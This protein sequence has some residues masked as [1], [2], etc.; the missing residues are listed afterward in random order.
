M[1]LFI[2]IGLV[3]IGI[4]LIYVELFLLPGSFVVGVLGGISLFVG[5]YMVYDTYGQVNGN[6][7]LAGSIVLFVISLIL[8]YRK[9]T[10]KEWQVDVNI[11]GK[12][13]MAETDA[14]E[15]GDRGVTF[16]V[17]RPAG[18]VNINDKRIEA[19]SQGEYI[20]KDQE[21]EVVRIEKEQIFVKP[22]NNS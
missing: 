9:I 18:K 15:V 8:G 3:V 14:V 17:L 5:V 1:D 19:F 11:D 22:I 6:Y 16:S 13:T 20:E 10:S 21:V 7:A 12:V 2:I 4:V